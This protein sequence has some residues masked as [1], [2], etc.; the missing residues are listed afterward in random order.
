MG[1]AFIIKW[2]HPINANIVLC[3]SRRTGCEKGTWV[4]PLS[5]ADALRWEAP[6]GREGPGRPWAAP[7]GPW[8]LTTN[9]FTCAP[10]GPRRPRAAPD[11]TGKPIYTVKYVGGAAPAATLLQRNHYDI[12]FILFLQA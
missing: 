1:G 10:G 11:G 7:G 12:Q 2:R 8:G 9:P 6:G 3:V 4:A 5:G